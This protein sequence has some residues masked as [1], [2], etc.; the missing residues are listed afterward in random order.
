MAALSSI[1][2]ARHIAQRDALLA[3]SRALAT[4]GQGVLG[5]ALDQALAG[6]GAV[7]LGAYGIQAFKNLK[8]MVG[9]SITSLGKMPAAIWIVS[10]LPGLMVTRPSPVANL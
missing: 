5:D 4:S 6:V 3:L 2:L 1:P 9:D 10:A 7:L 8:N